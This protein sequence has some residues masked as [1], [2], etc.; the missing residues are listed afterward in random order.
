MDRRMCERRE[1]ERM[2]VHVV[3]LPRL[4][5]WHVV[6]VLC[7]YLCCCYLCCVCTFVVTC[8]VF[9]C[10]V[11]TCVVCCYLFLCVVTLLCVVTCSCVPHSMLLTLFFFF[12]FFLFLFP[13]QCLPF[14]N[15]CPSL[16]FRCKEDDGLGSRV[17]VKNIPSTS[18][19]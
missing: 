19:I 10:V 4:G 18:V 5:R 8:V 2:F 12:F 3:L 11:F 15:V 1:S 7:L 14:I 9:T 16:C 6:L 13:H 17:G